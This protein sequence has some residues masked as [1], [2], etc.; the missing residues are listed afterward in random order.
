METPPPP[1]WATP[2]PRIPAS[3]TPPAT[4]APTPTQPAW[5]TS[6]AGRRRTSRAAPPSPPGYSAH[7][8]CGTPPPPATRHRQESHPRLGADRQRRRRR[9]ALAGPAVA[10]HR[11]TGLRQQ[12]L[13]RLLPAAAGRIHR[14]LLPA[15]AAT[16]RPAL[17]PHCAHQPLLQP[18]R[19]PTALPGQ[20][21][22]DTRETKIAHRAAGHPQQR[23]RERRQ[24]VRVH[25]SPPG[26]HRARAVRPQALRP[27]AARPRPL[28]PHPR[29]PAGH[30][31]RRRTR[32]PPA[33]G[34]IPLACSIGARDSI[35]CRRLLAAD[36]AS[37]SA[38]A[39]ARSCAA[40]SA[41]I[42]ALAP[43]APPR[44][45]ADCE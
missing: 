2:R 15:A 11:D 16:R 17:P 43:A 33:R 18:L 20:G 23:P 45:S 24:S 25:R 27:R 39:H 35:A 7:N 26:L 9:P 4:A 5:R 36:R 12:S 41:N 32:P 38:R 8:T 13:H 40:Y 21:G 42:A 3:W 34:T 44:T 22:P 31:A 19:P 14:V 37:A 6:T 1:G 10:V 29:R 28:P 30:R